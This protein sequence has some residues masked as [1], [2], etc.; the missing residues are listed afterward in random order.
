MA[1]LTTEAIVLSTVK[2]RET[3]LITTFLTRDYGKI[4]TISK[5]V[6]KEGSALPVLYEPFTQV[7][8]VF[9]EKHHSEIY[10]LSE[11]SLI[12]YFHGLRG[13][14]DK[15]AWASFLIELVDML[16][17][18]RETNTTLFVM[19]AEV[20]KYL[21]HNP[22]SPVVAAFTVRLLWGSGSFPFIDPEQLRKI[23]PLERVYLNFEDG[24]LTGQDSPRAGTAYLVSKSLLETIR[25]L[26]ENDFE[27]SLLLKIPREVEHS[28]YRLI[29]G[30]VYYRYEQE[31]DTFRF[32]EELQII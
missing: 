11:S 32:L 3:S 23:G 4:K 29:R 27:K 20:L 8:I 14:L 1:I 9:Y 5:G 16:T 17:S 28:L 30:W 25:F 15:I 13:D 24:E 22:P 31:L 6:R 21:E 7:Q 19:L 18:L 2:L 26:M 12:R 10:F